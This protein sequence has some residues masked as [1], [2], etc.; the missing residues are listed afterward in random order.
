MSQPVVESRDED[1]VEAAGNA[2]ATFFAFVLFL[3]GLA[4]FAISFDVG[5]AAPWTFTGGILA[6]GLAFA[7]PTTILPAIEDRQGS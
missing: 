7:L 5:D 4:L 1:S 3:G 2:V 6:I